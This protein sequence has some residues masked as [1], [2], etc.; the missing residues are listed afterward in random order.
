MLFFLISINFNKPKSVQFFQR[1]VM[2]I[3]KKMNYKNLENLKLFRNI[4]L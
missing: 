2:V 4:F 3:G 1:I